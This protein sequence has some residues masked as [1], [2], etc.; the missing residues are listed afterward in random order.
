MTATPMM[1]NTMPSTMK[2]VRISSASS[3]PA[4]LRI[5][6]EAKLSSAD[7]PTAIKKALSA[8]R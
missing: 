2:N 1:S 4:W 3:S 8:Q 6:S 5:A 7:I